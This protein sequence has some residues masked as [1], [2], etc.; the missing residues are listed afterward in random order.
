LR[1]NGGDSHGRD[2]SIPAEE[3]GGGGGAYLSHREERLPSQPGER[4]WRLGLLPI[5]TEE[6]LGA[7]AGLGMTKERVPTGGPQ[8]LATRGEGCG[9]IEPVL[10]QRRSR[11]VPGA[12]AAELA[13]VDEG[14]G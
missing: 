2:S 7:C 14:G 13:R 4:Q 10:T 5:S 9:K 12:L 1:G 6:V 11:Y 8:S 3:H